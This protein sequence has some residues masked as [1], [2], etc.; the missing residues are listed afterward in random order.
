MPFV[1]RYESF[2]VR[3]ILQQ[4]E[5]QPSPVT[6]MGAHARGLH[7]APAVP[8]QRTQFTAG[9]MDRTHKRPGESNNQ[10]SNR[11]GTGTTSGFANMLAQSAALMQALNSQLGQRGLAILDRPAYAA[12][13]LRLKLVVHA[14]GETG[15]LPVDGH[16]SGMQARKTL[17]NLHTGGIAGI[18]AIIDRGPHGTELFVQTCFPIF[19]DAAGNVEPEEASCSRQVNGN[20][21]PVV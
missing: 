9:M 18:R 16:Q 15:F 2:E 7:A 19:A 13:S 1:R 14:T 6:G 8:H 12:D 3:R 17:G 21:V 4:S 20:W 11:G 10:F 5:N